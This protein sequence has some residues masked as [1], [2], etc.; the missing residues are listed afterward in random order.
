MAG[1]TSLRAIGFE[2]KH[3][4]CDEVP[5]RLPQVVLPYVVFCFRRDL[6]S[7]NIGQ[8]FRQFLDN[9]YWHVVNFV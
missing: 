6:A 2:F 8:I 3:A 4:T 9:K 7:M 5:L 1:S